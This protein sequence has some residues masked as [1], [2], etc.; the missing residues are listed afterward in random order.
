MAM[1]IAATP[2]LE[3]ADAAHFLKRME[4]WAS[5]PV[6]LKEVNIDN[7]VVDKAVEAVRARRAARMK[8]VENAEQK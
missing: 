5:N 1:Q 3:G 7:K 4:F 2:V 6:S 8:A